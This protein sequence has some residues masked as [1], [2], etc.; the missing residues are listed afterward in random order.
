M[1]SD[2]ELEEEI[3]CIFLKDKKKKR[4]TPKQQNVQNPLGRARKPNSIS[5]HKVIVHR[6]QICHLRYAKVYQ[7]HL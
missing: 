5:K 2:L 3:F 6:S 1:T 4:S 7:L